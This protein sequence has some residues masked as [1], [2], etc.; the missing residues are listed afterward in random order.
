MNS[1]KYKA[2]GIGFNPDGMLRLPIWAKFSLDSTLNIIPIDWTSR[3]LAFLAEIPAQGKVF[4][5]VHHKPPKVRW[6]N[7]VSL[8]HMG[9]T[10]LRYGDSPDCEAKSFLGK[11]QRIFDRGTDPYIPYITHEAKFDVS[12]LV[13]VLG[14][15][16]AP[17][18]DVDD[19]LIAKWLDYAISVNFG[20]D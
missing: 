8:K 2:A 4:H 9:I 16:Y 18:P 12:N 5:V 3:V 6:L 19:A 11:L 15:N 1:K 10:G 13:C 20:R 7:D 14:K 17:P